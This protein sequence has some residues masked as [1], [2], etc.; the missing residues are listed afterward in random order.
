MLTGKSELLGPLFCALYNIKLRKIHIFLE[1]MEIFCIFATEI[2]IAEK[3]IQQ[4]NNTED[5]N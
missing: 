4:L 1:W 2:G 3:K 5:E